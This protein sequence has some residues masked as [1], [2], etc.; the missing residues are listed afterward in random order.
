MQLDLC[1]GFRQEANSGNADRFK[2]MM[3]L[4]FISFEKAFS[5][6]HF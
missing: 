4:G 5:W 2:K 1:I 3:G 6:M